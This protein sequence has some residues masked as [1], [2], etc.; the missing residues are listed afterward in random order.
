MQRIMGYLHISHNAPI[1]YQKDTKYT[2]TS[3]IL[4][5]KARECETQNISYKLDFSLSSL[6]VQHK[7]MKIPL[8]PKLQRKACRR[9]ESRTNTEICVKMQ[10]R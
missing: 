2:H 4:H 3:K 5:T 7:N 1:N 10:E 6:V 8:I 9:F